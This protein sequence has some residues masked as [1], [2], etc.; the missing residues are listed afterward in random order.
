[1]APKKEAE[2]KG[3]CCGRADY[4]EGDFVKGDDSDGFG[5]WNRIF[6]VKNVNKV[7]LK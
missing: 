1:M 6:F 7:R 2:H 3:C 4:K 5:I